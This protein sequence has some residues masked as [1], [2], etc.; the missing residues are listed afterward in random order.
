MEEPTLTA[1]ITVPDGNAELSTNICPTRAK[2]IFRNPDT[3][4]ILVNI[5]ELV[6]ASNLTLMKEFEPLPIGLNGD[7]FP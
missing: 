2:A 1:V 7:N 5:L 6:A 4:V 3:S